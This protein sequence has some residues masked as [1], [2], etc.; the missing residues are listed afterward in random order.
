M[1]FWLQYLYLKKTNTV[2]I[3]RLHHHIE[4]HGVRRMASA[5]RFNC[6]Q[7][8]KLSIQ[9]TSIWL[10]IAQTNF[11]RFLFEYYVCSRGHQQK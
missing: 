3:L 11:L 9:K 6:E 2:T 10:I 8:S 7:E 5:R 4:M 1:N